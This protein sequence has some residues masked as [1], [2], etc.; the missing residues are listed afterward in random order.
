MTKGKVKQEIY[1]STDVEADG[2]LPGLSSMLSFA[3]AAYDIEKNIVSTF[4]RNLDLLAGATPDEETMA[5][6]NSTPANQAAYAV[7]RVD[8]ANPVEAM[9][10]Y[11]AWLKSLPGTPVFVGYPAPYDFKWI[12]YYLIMFAG[13]NPFSFSRVIDVKSYA[14]AVL[15][16]KRFLSTSKKNFP[17]Q[18]FDKLP[19]THIAL[20]DAIEQGAMWINLLRET[21]GLDRL[22]DV[23]VKKGA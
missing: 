8:T 4:S 2:K 19:H 17:K 20:D 9:R 21:S 10:E 14:Y 16:Q 13:S 3:S 23:V 6:W 22:P 7:T 12:D 15:K 18:W 1:V 5:W 11:K